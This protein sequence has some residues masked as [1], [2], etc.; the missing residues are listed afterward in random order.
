MH[1]LEFIKQKV[2][3]FEWEKLG[4]ASSSKL[5]IE[6]ETNSFTLFM[7]SI[8]LNKAEVFSIYSLLSSFIRPAGNS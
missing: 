1:S 4:L 5:Q 2:F 6:S 8:F 7:S 3:M